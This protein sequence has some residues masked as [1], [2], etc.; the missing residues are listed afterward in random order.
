MDLT[1]QSAIENR[2][3]AMLVECVPNFSEGRKGETVERIARAIESVKGA[4]V[5]NRHLDTDHNRSVITFVA[6]PEHVV[7]AAL[8]AVATAAE[9]IDL[10]DHTGEHPRIGATDVLPFVPVSGVTMD[11]CVTLAHH[12]GQRIWQELSIPVYFYERA[13]LR[14]DRV[15]L[16]NVRGKG[17]RHL[18]E[19][20]KTNPDRAPDVG[21]PKLHESAGAIAVGARPF[22]IAFNVNLRT[23]D[24]SIARRI[25]RAVRERDGGLPFVKALGFELH[26]RGLVQVSMNL[27]DY[28]QTTIARAFAAV[29]H[30]ATRLGVEISGAEIVGLVPRAA[31]DRTAAYFPLL[32]N[33]RETL[34]LETLLDSIGTSWK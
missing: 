7:D 12:A 27:V 10:R 24:V 23:R 29:R 18:R 19:E 26:S 21:E 25:A 31:L 17:F 3:S 8:R 1:D 30:E 13:A 28:E 14:P 9:L 22:L 2:K 20:I 4:T 15:R 16:E 32:E 11:Q 34:V 6:E 33:F 5:L